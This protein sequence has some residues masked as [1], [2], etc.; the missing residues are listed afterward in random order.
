MRAHPGH[1]RP[2][3]HNVRIGSFSFREKTLHRLRGLSLFSANINSISSS[4]DA[5]AMKARESFTD[6]KC[7]A[8]ISISSPIPKSTPCL[9][10]ALEESGDLS[11]R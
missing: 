3:C 5:G 10:K 1:S 9:A 11:F 4:R 6:L 2:T 8:A 7:D